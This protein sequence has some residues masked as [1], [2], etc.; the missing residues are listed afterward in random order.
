MKTAL[1]QQ[2]YTKSK[3]QTLTC[4]LKHIKIAAQEG[5]ELIV[6]QE[7]HQTEYFCKSEDTKFFTYANSFEEDVKFWS[8]VAKDN[9]VVL[10]TSL[11][12]KRTAGL[13]HNTAVVFEK[14]G[15]IAG[16]YRKMHIPDDPGFYEKFYFTPGDLGFE[17]IQ[18]SV[19]KLGVLICWDQWYPEAARIMTLK[20]AEILIYPTAIGWFDEDSKEEKERQLDSWITIQRSHAIA[21]A[22]PLIS[23]NRVGFEADP[24]A[25]LAGTRFWGNSFICGVQ[26]EILAE[27]KHQEESILYAD[28][29]HE[30]TKEVRDIWPFLRD[31][32]IEDYDCLLKRYCDTQ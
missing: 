23:C 4:T 30:R 29:V 18:T 15:S 16:K 11:F 20:G 28:I 27:A 8:T 7:L 32:R 25:V 6:L 3:A 5:A 26:G 14:D 10:V 21:N 31:R 2:A 12:E 1:I 17:P 9:A 22:I 24:T 19:G 13:Y